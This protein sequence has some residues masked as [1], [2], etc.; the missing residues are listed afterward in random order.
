VRAEPRG[1][2]RRDGCLQ[3]VQEAQ[4][5]Q[6][7]IAS[8]AIARTLYLARKGLNTTEALR[9]PVTHL[10]RYNEGAFV[11]RAPHVPI[12]PLAVCAQYP[13]F[14]PLSF[15]EAPREE[16]VQF[17]DHK[18]TVQVQS[19]QLVIGASTRIVA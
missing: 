11:P 13:R 4:T 17:H 3:Y 8:R 16:P 12:F 14:S 15:R 7:A 9:A 6:N 5:R 2:L 19:A 10:M 1:P 18:M